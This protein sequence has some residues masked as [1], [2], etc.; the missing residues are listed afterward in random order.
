[1]NPARKESFERSRKDII[2]YMRD[3]DGEQKEL[4]KKFVNFRML[5]GKRTRVSPIL[6]NTFHRPVRSEGDGINLLG[7]AVDHI[8]PICE[9]VKVRVAGTLYDVPGL[10]GRD[11][12]Q[13]CNNREVEDDL[14]FCLLRVSLL[15]FNQ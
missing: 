12:Q 10:L 7:Q 2:S 14:S 11:R 6:Y 4:I 5:H 1:M 3:L 9:V 8:K 13:S 15:G